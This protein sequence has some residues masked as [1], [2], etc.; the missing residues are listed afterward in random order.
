M[1][2][3]GIHVPAAREGVAFVVAGLVAALMAARLPEAT[4]DTRWFAVVGGIALASVG[5]WF[6]AYRLGLGE[7]AP[8]FVFASC[9]AMAFNFAVFLWALD[10]LRSVGG[11]HGLTLF[12]GEHQGMNW[13]VSIVPNRYGL[14]LSERHI[15]GTDWATHQQQA[16]QLRRVAE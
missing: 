13:L 2:G 9:F 6:I 14:W 11:R 4:G 3:E 8:A 12:A 1:Q 7:K 5:A 15:R 16:P 10:W